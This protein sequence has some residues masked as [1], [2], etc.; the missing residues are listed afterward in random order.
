MDTL[1]EGIKSHNNA[2]ITPVLFFCPYS[3]EIH[4]EAVPMLHVTVEDAEQAAQQIAYE[5]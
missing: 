1:W 2:G 3:S 5:V 4:Y